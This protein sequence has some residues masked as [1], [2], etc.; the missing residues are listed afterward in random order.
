[1]AEAEKAVLKAHYNEKGTKESHQEERAA[2]KVKV[3]LNP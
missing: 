3:Y 2:K 1:M